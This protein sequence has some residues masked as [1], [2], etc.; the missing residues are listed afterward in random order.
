LISNQP[1]FLRLDPYLH[2]DKRR[3]DLGVMNTQAFK[4]HQSGFQDFKISR[5][6]SQV[7]RRKEEVWVTLCSYEPLIARISRFQ[8]FKISRVF[9]LMN[10]S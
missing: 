2:I 9:V 7:L 1:G 10:L 6:I 8:D 4:G 3:G 5:V